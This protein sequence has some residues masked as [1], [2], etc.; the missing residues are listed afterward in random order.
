MECIDEEDLNVLQKFLWLGLAGS[1][2]TLARYGLAGVVHRFAGAGFPWGTLAVNVLGCFLAGLLWGLFEYR[3]EF[4]P[5]ARMMVLIGFIGAFT[6]FAGYVVETGELLRDAQ[7]FSAAANLVSQN[8]LG[9]AA[10]LA[11]LAISRLV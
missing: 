4:P 2:G 8:V 5:Q 9:I 7:W 6:T 11:G 1:L 3:L 10:M